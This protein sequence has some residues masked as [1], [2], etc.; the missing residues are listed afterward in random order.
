MLNNLNSDRIMKNE[1]KYIAK[2]NIVYNEWCIV[3][4]GITAKQRDDK[5][6]QILIDYAKQANG[7]EQS[8][9]NCNIPHVRQQSELLLAFAKWIDEETITSLL[10]EPEH[11]VER[12][13]KANNCG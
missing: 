4:N 8:D 7:A 10:A 3:S 13:L 2:I 5:I 12:Y 1:Y 9:S 11:Y 6:A